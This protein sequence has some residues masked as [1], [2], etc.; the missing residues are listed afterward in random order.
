M[1]ID[2][3]KLH[4]ECQRGLPGTVYSPGMSAPVRVSHRGDLMTM[5]LGKQRATLADEGRYFIATNPTVGTGVAGIAGTGAFSDA[6][7]LLLL[8]N[9]NA[10]GSGKRIVLDML[11]LAPTVAG[12]N[13]TD[14]RYVSKTDTGDRYTSGGSAI[15]PVN[16]NADS[17]ELPTCLLYFGA[18]VTTAAS[19]SA[20]LIGNG[21]LRNVI[22]VVGD[23]YLF[24]FGGDARPVS[25]AIAGTAIARMVI[26]HAPVV[27]GPGQS[28][29]M[30][31]H[32][33]AQTVGTSYEFELGFWER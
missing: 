22:T 5:P 32:A 31:L 13:G 11:R 2:D 33:A 6:E 12:T 24:D 20:R 30:S 23:E 15:T 21:L 27:L 4:G 14:H 7:S 10:V 26:P 29:V 8:K 9:T 18:L 28:F 19:S 16:P 17:T 3:V 1:A 25:H